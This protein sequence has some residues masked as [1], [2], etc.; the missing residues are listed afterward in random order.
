MLKP[1]PKRFASPRTT[2]T[3]A[4]SDVLTSFLEAQTSRVINDTNSQELSHC[5]LCRMFM[6]NNASSTSFW[7]FS[8][9]NMHN[10]L[11]WFLSWCE[12]LIRIQGIV[13][14]LYH[15]QLFLVWLAS[16]TIATISLS[17]LLFWVALDAFTLLLLSS[18]HDSQSVSFHLDIQTRAVYWNL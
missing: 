15:S 10:Q 12:F 1:S 9:I 6:D 17:L 13:W 8:E 18:Q 7:L 4:E 3:P 14:S 11:S 5:I 16:D 2:T